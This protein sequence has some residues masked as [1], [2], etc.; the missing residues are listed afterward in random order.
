MNNRRIASVIAAASALSTFAGSA[1]AFS[2]NPGYVTEYE[3]V[4]VKGDTGQ[5]DKLKTD[6]EHHKKERF[7]DM[8]EFV[9]AAH[10]E[11]ISDA[12]LEVQKRVLAEKNEMS[13]AYVQAAKKEIKFRRHKKE[14]QR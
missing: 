1:G 11:N 14:D 7:A 6:F 2:K 9:A 3:P 13:E 4:N 5:Y 10:K 8:R 12:T